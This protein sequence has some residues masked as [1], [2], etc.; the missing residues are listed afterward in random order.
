MSA[1]VLVVFY[2]QGRLQL[3]P[4]TELRRFDAAICASPESR[5]NRAFQ[6]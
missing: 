2:Q 4:E 1:D 6:H 3:L 5:S